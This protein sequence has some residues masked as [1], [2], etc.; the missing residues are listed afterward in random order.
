MNFRRTAYVAT[1]TRAAAV[2]LAVTVTGLAVGEAQAEA[3]RSGFDS[4]DM[5]RNDDGSISVSLPFNVNFFGTT[6]SDAYVNNNGNVTFDDELATYTPFNLQ[7]TNR[8]IIAP[9]FADVET[10]K[11]GEPVRYGSGTVDGRNAFGVNW[12]DVDYYFFNEPDHDDDLKLNS[13]QLILIDRSDIGIGDFDIEFNYDKI[14]WEAGQAS[15][16]IEG[17]GGDSARV[18]FS[19]GIDTSFELDGSAVNGAFLD[20]NLDTGL[21]HNSLNSDVD[22][23]YRFAVRN[24]LVE[25]PVVPSPAA[26]GLGLAM[27]GLMA[28]RRRPRLQPHAATDCEKATRQVAGR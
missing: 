14:T 10:T 26:A 17:L 6:Y 11:Y 13:F 2:A 16:G 18:G 22:G 28:M 15:G 9:F 12:V 5:F 19:N 23:R 7:S 8:S 20:D 4:D 21:I 1:W 24:G 25:T 27:M 3:L